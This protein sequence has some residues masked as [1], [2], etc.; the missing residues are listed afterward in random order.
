[1][2]KV[3]F[4]VLISALMFVGISCNNQTAE[5][6]KDFSEL[7]SD[8]EKIYTEVSYDL[9]LAISEVKYD[10]NGEL[11]AKPENLE[12]TRVITAKGSGAQVVVS[13]SF[14]DLIG[15]TYQ[16]KITGSAIYTYNYATITDPFYSSMSGSINI[17]INRSGDIHSLI[18][19]LESKT[20]KETGAII[21]AVETGTF[22]KAKY[23]ESM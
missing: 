6:P 2:K 8:Q 9:A 12:V 11:K 4:T 20:N 13:M 7:T 10:E 16:D 22:D 18:S 17:V 14:S 21:S 5:T 15:K 1:M 19:N 3:F 23:R